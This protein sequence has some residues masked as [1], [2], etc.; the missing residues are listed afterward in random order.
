MTRELARS[1]AAGL[2]EAG[3]RRMFGVPGGGPNLDMIGAAADEGIDFTLAHSETASCIMASTFGR[4]TNSV[5]AAVVTRGP[6]F[7]SASNGMAQALLDRYPLLLVSDTMS[8]ASI[9]RI[10]H[11][12]LDQ[13]AAAAPL[14]KFSGTLS[15]NSPEDAVRAAIATAMTSPRGSVHLAFDARAEGVAAPAPVV[16]AP[17]SVE[18]RDQ[19]RALIAG[20]KRP[21]IVIGEDAVRSVD[22][23]RA[24]LAGINAPIMVTYQAMGVIPSDW[25]TYAGLFTGVAADRPL[26]ADVDLLLG[27]G[28]DSIEPMPGHEPTTAPTVILGSY[29]ADV[30]YF[31]D[32]LV[33]IGEYT[34]LLADVISIA[35][36]DWAADA[37]AAW[38][39]GRVAGLATDVEGFSPQSLVETTFEFMA[40]ALVTVDAGAHMLAVMPLWQTDEPDGV[41][42]SNGLATMGFALPAAIGAAF[43]R[44]DRRVVCFTGDGGLGMVL[45]ELE[46]LS[47]A[48]LNITVVVFNDATL[49]L[50]KLKQE[51]A[52]GGSGAVG[53][54]LVDFAAIANA[55]GLAGTVVTNVDELRATLGTVTTGPSLIDARVDADCYPHVIKA[56][57][58]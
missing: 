12:R 49:S 27:I 10:G 56:V 58:G 19:A 8:Q 5:G 2:K 45:A 13:V 20:A 9:S 41:L 22:A 36:T 37:G 55:M 32:P 57:R 14:T 52:Q 43:A 26:F 17:S 16:V 7:T 18:V 54:A 23:V 33:V 1:L 28:V 48:N 39:A 6:G 15:K 40:D 44:P 38:W 34:D 11:Q 47:R 24:A 21:I 3:V 35:E 25:P 31:D 30:R 29:A 53:Y 51:Q 50:I 4:L 42:I 46:V